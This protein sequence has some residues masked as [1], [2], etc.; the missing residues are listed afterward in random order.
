MM[1]S[2]Y[3]ILIIL[4]L[5]YLL[6][7]GNNLNNGTLETNN[8]ESGLSDI[9]IVDKK[10]SIEEKK[11]LLD[12]EEYYNEISDLTTV[13][14]EKLGKIIVIDAG[15]QE[16]GNNEKEPI[17]PNSTVMKAK[18]SSG[19]SGV[20][21]GLKEYQLNIKVALKLK[22]ELVKRGY[23]VIMIRE[24]DDVN[25][26]NSERAVLAND[27]NA[28]AFIRIHANGDENSNV[29][30]IM[31]ISPTKNNPYIADLYED[32]NKLS[33]AILESMVRAT[34]ANSKGVWE[35]D[36]MSGINWCKVPVTIIEMGYMTNPS[37]D[38]LMSTIEYQDNIVNG[39]A[40]GIDNYFENH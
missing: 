6:Q 22:I 39:I 23:E 27:A 19:T 34:S 29:S 33:I 12:Y 37:E 38:K 26:S 4:P 30:G 17:G 25:I 36:S 5:L 14:Q 18:V 15:H 16:K 10:M 21:S 9:A 24:T 8:I 31:T 11:N 28:D 35:T 32:C 2:K 20:I 1:K 13:G 3:M 40:N 7:G